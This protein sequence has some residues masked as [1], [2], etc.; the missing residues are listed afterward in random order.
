MIEVNDVSI[1]KERY[2]IGLTRVGLSIDAFLK[3]HVDDLADEVASKAKE[4]AP[5]G[6]TNRLKTEGVVVH[7]EDFEIPGE[8]RP[9]GEL[10][11]EVAAFG[12]GHSVRGA[13]GRFTAAT[14]EFS[15][16]HIFS[17]VLTNHTY[18][19][20]VELNP[21][22]RHAKWVHQG[23]GLYGPYHSP[24]VPVRAPRLVFYWHGRKWR[25]RSVR[26]QKPQPFLDQA[27]EYVR[28][29]YE[30]AKLS[31]LRAEIDAVT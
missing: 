22:I 13:G 1:E 23:T 17:G 8:G 15:P 20:F 24:I 31:V 3:D 30:P 7:K 21:L 10:V 4:L 12:G 14:K 16:G 6:P 27:Y 19:A 9:G 18:Q 2:R 28:N 5:R 11:T 26:G 25:K 29:V